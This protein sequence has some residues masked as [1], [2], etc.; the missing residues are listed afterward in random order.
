MFCLNELFFE[1]DFFFYLTD[2]QEKCLLEEKLLYLQKFYSRKFI[3][4]IIVIWFLKFI[5]V[6]KVYSL[7]YPLFSEISRSKSFEPPHVFS[8]ILRYFNFFNTRHEK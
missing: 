4:R 3:D 6:F 1:C 8:I 2:F 5:L 7:N